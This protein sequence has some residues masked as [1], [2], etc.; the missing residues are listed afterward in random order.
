VSALAV[1]D[2]VL[3]PV[4]PGAPDAWALGRVLKKIGE[5]QIHRPEL[6]AAVVVNRA[7]RTRVAMTVVGELAGVD[8]VTHCPVQIG[9]RAAIAEAVAAGTGATVYAGGSTAGVEIR[10]L[11]DWLLGELEARGHAA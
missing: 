11:A 5:M 2:Y 1:A 4:A 3:V 8:G 9:N 7:I 10:R 6:R